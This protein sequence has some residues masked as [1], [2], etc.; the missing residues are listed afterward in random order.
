MTI[1]I[2]SVDPGASTG[3]RKAKKLAL[4]KLIKDKKAILFGKFSKTLE[5]KN[6]QEAWEEVRLKTLSLQLCAAHRD[7]DFGR[8]KM[9]RE[10]KVASV[11][12]CNS[13]RCNHF[14]FTAS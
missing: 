4:L 9:W 3:N 12:S 14:S 8:D 2:C 1:D 13:N 7:R 10:W 6:K 5:N 11:V